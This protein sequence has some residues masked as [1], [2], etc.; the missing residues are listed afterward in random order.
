MLKSYSPQDNLSSIVLFIEIN[1]DP[2]LR[3]GEYAIRSCVLLT[4]KDDDCVE[5]IGS[6]VNITIFKGLRRIKD[7]GKE[8]LCSVLACQCPTSE[9]VEWV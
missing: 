8:E 4:P 7:S 9:N 3:P 5:G 6:L 1:N 2:D